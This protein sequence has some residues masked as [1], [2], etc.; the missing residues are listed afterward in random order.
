VRELKQEFISEA[1]TYQ[2]SPLDALVAARIAL[3]RP[4]ITAGRDTFV[5]TH[6]MAGL[7]QDDSSGLLNTSYPVTAAITV[8]ANG[9]GSQR[10]SPPLSIPRAASK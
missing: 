7:P 9:A 3:P 5:Y 4:N 10:L 8:P 6:P 2:V 1:K